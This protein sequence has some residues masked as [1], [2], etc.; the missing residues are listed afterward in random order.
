MNRI[1]QWLPTW[2]SNSDAALFYRSTTTSLFAYSNYRFAFPPLPALSAYCLCAS[3]HTRRTWRRMLYSALSH[4]HIAG[5]FM[6][7]T[8]LGPN[9]GAAIAL[10]ALLSR[11]PAMY[12]PPLAQNFALQT[13]HM[14]PMP[15]IKQGAYLLIRTAHVHFSPPPFSLSALQRPLPNPVSPCAMQCPTCA[16]C[17]LNARERDSLYNTCYKLYYYRY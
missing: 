2:S 14:M 17:F 1:L 8:T 13:T 4:T 15:L 9:M 6:S 11:T 3:F 5:R 12:Y 16:F 10:S 7:A